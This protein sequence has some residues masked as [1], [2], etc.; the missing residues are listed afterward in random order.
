[1]RGTAASFKMTFL[2]I[3]GTKCSKRYSSF[4]KSLDLAA[5]GCLLAALANPDLVLRLKA[6]VS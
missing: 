2:L 6:F 1:M 5:F 4:W 3:F